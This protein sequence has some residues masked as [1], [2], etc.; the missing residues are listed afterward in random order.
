MLSVFGSAAEELEVWASHYTQG[1]PGRV[2]ER[3]SP[4]PTL[5]TASS[6]APAAASYN[7]ELAEL[8]AEPSSH[9]ASGPVAEIRDSHQTEAR[10]GGGRCGTFWL[11]FPVS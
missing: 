4:A 6:G 2:S 3:S 1:E 7:G 5:A 8:L 11:V 9:P 10:A